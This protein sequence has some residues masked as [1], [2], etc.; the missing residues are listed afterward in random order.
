MY[1]AGYYNIAQGFGTVHATATSG[2]DVAL[3]YGTS[4]DDFLHVAASEAALAALDYSAIAHGFDTVKAFAGEGGTDT[5]DEQAH[6]FVLKTIG[7]WLS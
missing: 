7:D 5:L 4:G 3:L 6:D 1:G 2:N